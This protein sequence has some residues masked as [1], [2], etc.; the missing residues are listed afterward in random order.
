MEEKTED[1][2]IRAAEEIFLRDGYGASRMQD[3]ADK[4]GINK[5][6]L[7]Y[8]FRSKDK[9]FEYIFEKKVAIMFPEM[10]ILMSGDK[11]FQELV[12]IFIEKYIRLLMENSYLPLFVMSTINSPNRTDFLEKLP[13][14]FLK[15][16]IT[17]YYRD[18]SE[19]KIAEVNPI[20][21]VF[22]LLGMCAFPFMA[23]PMIQKM[24]MADEEQ[25]KQLMELRIKELQVYVKRIIV[26]NL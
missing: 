24:T 5:A 17:A 4:A 12:E 14:S 13:V 11:D 26:V 25:F 20:Q 7:H 23:K 8:Y 19:G 22:S 2:I 9:L 15:N 6:M 16:L 21:F 18:F 10:E 1:K 3:I